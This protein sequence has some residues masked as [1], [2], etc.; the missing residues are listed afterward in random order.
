MNKLSTSSIRSN[1]HDHNLVN[2]MFFLG[3]TFNELQFNR[4]GDYQLLPIFFSYVIFLEL[5]HT[6]YIYLVFDRHE[7]ML[8]Q[9]IIN[10][11]LK[12][13]NSK[14]LD[15]EKNMV[16]MDSRL[17]ELRS[18]IKIESNDDVRMIGIYRL[19]GTGKTTISKVVYNDISHL[20]E[21]SIFLADVRE[22]SQYYEA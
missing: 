9:D 14:L 11:I 10:V 13:L 21:S 16:R 1:N 12:N 3:F 17:E 7:E 19:L 8:I 6:H 20:F 22:R 18:L 2:W 5:I 15:V 4:I